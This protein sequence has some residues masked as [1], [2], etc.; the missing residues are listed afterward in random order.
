MGFYAASHDLLS[1][2]QMNCPRTQYP[3]QRSHLPTPTNPNQ[4]DRPQS[5]KR[6]LLQ[7]HPPNI[8]SPQK[9]TASRLIT[10]KASGATHTQE[11]APSHCSTLC[12]VPLTGLPKGHR[13]RLGCGRDPHLSRSSFQFVPR[14]LLRTKWL[15]Q[16]N[17]FQSSEYHSG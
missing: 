7:T 2:R 16:L 4:G 3:N 1:A 17:W 12:L 15:P 5:E 10:V 13:H 14:G 8:R 6:S 9:H 11:I